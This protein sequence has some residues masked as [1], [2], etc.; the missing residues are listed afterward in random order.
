MNFWFR[1]PSIFHLIALIYSIPNFLK[2]SSI[3]T[4]STSSSCP[5]HFNAFQTAFLSL[6][7]AGL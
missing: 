7:Q 3:F 4:S 1:I 5:A 6:P 2:E